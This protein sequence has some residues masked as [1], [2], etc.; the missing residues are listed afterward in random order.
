MGSPQVELASQIRVMV[1]LSHN[2][3][4]TPLLST[5]DGSVIIETSIGL[6]LGAK[7]IPT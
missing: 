6:L 7:Y 4:G 2:K 3:Y 5:I 1:E